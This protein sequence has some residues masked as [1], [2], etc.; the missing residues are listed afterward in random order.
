MKLILKISL[1]ALVVAVR[2]AMALPPPP[3]LPDAGATALLAGL[4]VGGLLVVKNL[5]R[6][7]N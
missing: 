6:K 2:P 5:L 3:S 4:S 1:I 7:K